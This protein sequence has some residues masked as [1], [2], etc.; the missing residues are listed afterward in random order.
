MKSFAG[1]RVDRSNSNAVFARM[2][3]LKHRER[4]W[5]A[6]YD[7]EQLTSNFAKGSKGMWL[8]LTV[9]FLIVGF[10]NPLA[11][12]GDADHGYPKY[13]YPEIKEALH[14]LIET[15]DSEKLKQSSQ[16]LLDR[17]IYIYEP[18]LSTGERGGPDILPSEFID[19]D[20]SNPQRA[21]QLYCTDIE[22]KYHEGQ[23]VEL[24]SREYETCR[25]FEMG[26]KGLP[27]DTLAVMSMLEDDMQVS[28]N[29]FESVKR[30]PQGSA[31][32]AT[33]VQ[34]LPGHQSC[35]K[36]GQPSLTCSGY[37]AACL[38]LGN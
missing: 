13:S 12:A 8:S 3:V 30:L 1:I 18:N 35:L 22:R 7:H 28:T 20:P 25:K 31:Y 33:R 16:I 24:L 21:F 9:F 26:K 17:L 2:K 15:S 10:F 4:R 14:K 36:S 23:N 11:H 38:V 27:P 29:F 32:Q 37:L 34:C 5:G 19:L 6:G